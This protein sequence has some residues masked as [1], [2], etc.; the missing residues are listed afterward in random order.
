MD[1]KQAINKRKR[2]KERINITIDKTLKEALDNYKSKMDIDQL[3]PL[4]NEVLWDWLNK[5][6]EEEK[7]S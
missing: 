1:I 4:I 5:Q 6:E 3:S 2:Q 7:K